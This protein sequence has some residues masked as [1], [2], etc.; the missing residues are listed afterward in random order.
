MYN[1]IEVLP[2]LTCYWW[3]QWWQ[4]LAKLSAVLTTR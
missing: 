2:V 1:N 4:C 3:H